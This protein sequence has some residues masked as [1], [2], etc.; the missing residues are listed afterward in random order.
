MYSQ[1][2]RIPEEIIKSPWIR[3]EDCSAYENI[4][5]S[6]FKIF[7]RTKPTEWIFRCAEAYSN[8]EYKGNLL[9]LLDAPRPF[10]K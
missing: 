2:A 10:K 8:R 1:E 3:L 6:H 9:D 4:G 5:I 7:G